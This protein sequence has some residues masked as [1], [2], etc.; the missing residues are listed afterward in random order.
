MILPPQRYAVCHSAAFS[1]RQNLVRFEIL[2][3]FNSATGPANFKALRSRRAS[4]SE[5]HPQIALR[6]IAGAGLYFSHENPPAD[7]QLQPRAD[8]IAI[9]FSTD[10]SNQ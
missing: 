2:Q 7:A 8:P 4:Q 6:Q 3:H 9:A 5:V 1:Y 10:R